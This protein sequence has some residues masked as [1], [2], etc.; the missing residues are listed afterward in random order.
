LEPVAYDRICGG[1]CKKLGEHC[2]LVS[3]FRRAI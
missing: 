1:G 3:R 2:L